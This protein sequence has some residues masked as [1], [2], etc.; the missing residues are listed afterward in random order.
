MIELQTPTPEGLGEAVTALRDWQVEGDPIQLHPGD[1]GWFWRFGADATAEAVRTWRRDGELV[2]VGM[3]DGGGSALRI[4]FAP[5]TK[6]D[7]VLAARI[8]DDLLGDAVLANPSAN[9]EVPQ[10]AV[11]RNVLAE[12][13]WQL[14]ESWTPLLR[15]L[16]AP[17]E[18][19]GIRIEVVDSTLAEVRCAIQRSAFEKSTFT[20][21]KWNAMVEGPAYRDARCLVGFDGVVA[22]GAITVWA[23][24]A[25]KPGLVE[26][27]AVHPDGRGKGIGRAMCLAGASALRELGSSSVWVCTETERAPAI[28]TYR[29][30]GFDELPVRLDLVR[31]V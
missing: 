7:R 16:S 17:V 27:L 6:S 21:E 11:L 19:P 28:A 9:L 23:A 5:D 15:D 22:V 25:G 31:S 1:L 13:G 2:A 14:D 20:I 30:A 3:L 10:D 29:S 26:P 18:D 4:A 8:R 24:G 12:S